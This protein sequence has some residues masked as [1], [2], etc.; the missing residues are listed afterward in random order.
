MP[1]FFVLIFLLL[2]PFFS[3]AQTIQGTVSKNSEAIPF[4]SVL[5]KKTERPDLIY[6]FTTT[7]EKGFYEIKLKSPLDSLIIEISSVSYEPKSIKVGNLQ[8]KQKHTSNFNLED[9]I[10]ELKEVSIESKQP[11]KVKNDTVTYDPNAFK[12]GS[13]RVVE[14]LIKKLPGMKVEENGEIKYKGKSIKKF[15]LDGDDLFDSQY[16][17][18]SKNINIDMVEKVQAVENFNMNPLLKGLVDSDD[19]ALNLVLKKGK[20]D[21]SG[22]MQIGYGIQDKYDLAA[23]TL[24]VSKKFK[25]FGIISYNNIGNNTSPY[26]FDSDVLSLDQMRDEKYLAPQLLHQGSFYSQLEEKFH[27]INRN[28]YAN[29]NALYKINSKITS[30]INL[31]IYDDRLKRR[32]IATSEFAIEDENFIISESENIIKK[33]QFYNANIQ[34]LHKPSDLLAIEY[35]GK[36]NYEKTDF[37]SKSSNNQIFQENAVDSKNFFTKQNFNLTKRINENSAFTTTALYA[38]NRSP[39]S[40]HLSPGILIQEDDSQII[41]NDQFSRFDKQTLKANAEYYI[42]SENS[43]FQLATGYNAVTND[44]NSRL[45][46]LSASGQEMLGGAFQNN[47]DYDFRMPYFGAGFSFNK[48]N[49]GFAASLISQYYSLDFLNKISNIQSKENNFILAPNLKLQYK[50]NKKASV[51]ASYTYNEVAPSEKNLFDGIILTNYRTFQNN[52]IDLHFLKTGSYVISYNFN[53]FF[54]LTSFNI[55]LNHNNRENNYFSR[56]TINPNTTVATSF[57][58]DS[59]NKDY[60]LN[61]NGEKY[62]HFLRTTFH[63]SA[64]YFISQSKNIVNGSDLRDIEN[65]GLFLNLIGRTGFKGN[66]NFENKI[67]FANSTFFLD[68]VNQNNFN[69]LK[70]SFKSILKIKENLRANAVLSF[71]SSDLAINNNYWFL[72]TEIRFKSKS[73][74]FDYT[75]VGRNLTNNKIFETISISDYSRSTSSHN[76]INRFVMASIGFNF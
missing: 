7:D 27:R 39:Q 21:F 46:S 70:N 41:E 40:Y 76:L 15:L 72:D 35:I 64:N 52:E 24:A 8:Q 48:N 63:T 49:F 30:K 51:V 26:S 3:N 53:N 17:I 6:Q 29:A 11:I 69:S 56:N 22:N 61:M 32:N 28:L 71:I 74:K 10:T 62:I 12:D 4:V 19:A 2:F 50:F 73:K 18:G 9:R 59:G 42:K 65:R 25:G 67:S 31:G 1:K 75:I 43:K 54:E 38:K 47:I 23:T 45:N 66:L 13:E 34:V 14:D 16:A 57:L 5:L 37:E 55:S 33:P 44:V 68:G 58:L 20:T 60:S 36:I